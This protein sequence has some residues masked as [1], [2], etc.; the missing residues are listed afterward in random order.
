MPLLQVGD[1]FAA[2]V[3]LAVIISDNPSIVTAG[4][5]AATTLIGSQLTYTIKVDANRLFNNQGADITSVANGVVV[6]AVLDPNTSYVSGSA[7]NGGFINTDSTDTIPDGAIQWNLGSLSPGASQNL[8]YAVT[9]LSTAPTATTQD[10]TNTVY[11]GRYP[12]IKLLQTTAP[13]STLM[14]SMRCGRSAQIKQSPGQKQT[15]TP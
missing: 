14:C 12:M 7:S 13:S 10:L 5:D 4:E 2:D 15:R 1:F 9:V 8:T 3:D 11:S 6:Y